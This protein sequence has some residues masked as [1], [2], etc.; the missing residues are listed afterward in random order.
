MIRVRLSSVLSFV[1]SFP[2]A[3]GAS[4]LSHSLTLPP[5]PRPL[6]NAQRPTLAPT[7]R[8]ASVSALTSATVSSPLAASSSSPFST[9]TSSSHHPQPQPQAPPQFVL[10]PLNID[11]N[12][13]PPGRRSELHVNLNTNTNAHS[14][15]TQTAPPT[16][17]CP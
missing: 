8:S 13:I 9:S 3:L 5:P 17:L 10:P 12:I 11:A 15:N 1:L 6:R 14:S 7:Q 16:Q 4:S 2:A